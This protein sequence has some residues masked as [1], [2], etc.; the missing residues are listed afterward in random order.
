MSILTYGPFSRVYRLTESSDD[1]SSKAY[2]ASERAKKIHDEEPD[3]SFPG[4][5][6][7]MAHHLAAKAHAEAIKSLAGGHADVYRIKD[8]NKRKAAIDHQ[9]HYNFHRAWSNARKHHVLFGY[10]SDPNSQHGGYTSGWHLGR[11]PT[12]EAAREV[13]KHIK[14]HS[15]PGKHGGYTHFKIK[16]DTHY[17]DEFKDE[18]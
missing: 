5:N 13:A 1:L 4:R 12:E 7:R 17:V 2:S 6:A 14:K 9:R 3:K 18:D 10:S 15:I 16:A 11:Y 8:L